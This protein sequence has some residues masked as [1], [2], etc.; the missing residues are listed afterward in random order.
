MKRQFFSLNF[1]FLGILR[2]T[3]NYQKQFE[4]AFVRKVLKRPEYINKNENK[5]YSLSKFDFL[6]ICHFIA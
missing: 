2:F 1:S 6:N 5:K 4:K 3:V